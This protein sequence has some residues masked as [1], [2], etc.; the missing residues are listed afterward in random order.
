MTFIPLVG[1][2]FTYFQIFVRVHTLHCLI[3]WKTNHQINTFYIN[4]DICFVC[5][6]WFIILGVSSNV[7]LANTRVIL[8]CFIVF[9][10]IL[11]TRVWWT[12]MMTVPTVTTPK[13]VGN[14]A[15][16]NSYS[17]AEYSIITQISALTAIFSLLMH[18]YLQYRIFC[19][20]NYLVKLIRQFLNV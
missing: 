13:L 2:D 10:S 6:Y 14:K 12:Q 4:N 15:F 3:E 9:L 8:C 5:L 7:F 18:L 17:C 20:N 19:S 16:Q 11:K 1:N